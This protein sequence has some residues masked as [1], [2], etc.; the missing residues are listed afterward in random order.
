MSSSPLRLQESCCSLLHV[1]IHVCMCEA[2]TDMLWLVCGREDNLCSFLLS[3][4]ESP[5]IELR[6]SIKCVHPPSHLP[7]PL[8]CVS[9]TEGSWPPWNPS[10]APLGEEN[11]AEEGRGVEKIVGHTTLTSLGSFEGH[12][13]PFPPKNLIRLPRSS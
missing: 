11:P 9:L 12:F 10:K 8:F 7:G 6:L 5:K 3:P 13:P 4:C 2:T 1:F